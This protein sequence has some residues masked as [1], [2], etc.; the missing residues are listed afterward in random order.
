MILAAQDQALRTNYTIDK[1]LETPL[2][3]LCRDATETVRHIVSG[4]KKLAQREYRRHH[5]KVVL[6]VHWEGCRK[7]GIECTDKWFDHQPWS[8]AENGGEDYLG[9]DYLHRQ[10]G[11]A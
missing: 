8:I 2:C 4:C 1:T 6:Q 11:E 9:H 7:Y 10:T 3:R 5:N